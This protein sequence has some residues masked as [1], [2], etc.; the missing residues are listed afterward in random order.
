MPY[1][2]RGRGKGGFWTREDDDVEALNKES[3]DEPWSLTPVGDGGAG[4]VKA[5]LAGGLPSGG[6]GVVGSPEVGETQG[7]Y[8][9]R[10][11]LTLMGIFP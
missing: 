7:V 4:G 1:P 6:E 2:V 11:N 10:P 5:T 9:G 8:F 3:E